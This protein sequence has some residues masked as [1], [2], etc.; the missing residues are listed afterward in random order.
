MFNI[1]SDEACFSSSRIMA[2][3]P[4][5]NWEALV[6]MSGFRLKQFYLNT[7]VEEVYE[8][9]VKRFTTKHMLYCF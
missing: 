4:D 2:F 1:S 9:D 5:F 7:T 6:F 3:I 8:K